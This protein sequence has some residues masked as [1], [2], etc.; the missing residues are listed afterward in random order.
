MKNKSLILVMSF[1]VVLFS[2]SAHAQESKKAASARKELKQA[3]VDSAADFQ[4]FKTESEIK[5][6]SNQKKIDELK[7]KKSAE[8]KE[9][10]QKYDNKVLAL[11]KS[12][13]DL[14]MKIRK[15][16]DTKTSKWTAFKK[17]FNHQMDELEASIS[18][19]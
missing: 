12:N 15:A 11:Q 19:I 8:T 1:A 16:D 14:K 13:D 6:S 17:E 9:V 2:F 5:I 3:K 18:R 10:R 4:K 7:V